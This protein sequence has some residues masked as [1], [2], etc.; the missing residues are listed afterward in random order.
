MIEGPSDCYVL[1][2]W[3]GRKNIYQQIG[4]TR[5]NV[6]NL[7]TFLHASVSKKADRAAIGSPLA[8]SSY[9][10]RMQGGMGDLL[11]F[12]KKGDENSVLGRLKTL[13][14][15]F[16]NTKNGSPQILAEY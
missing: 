10:S 2:D 3:K 8:A 1:I 4:R 12:L 15:H 6:L 14:K 5:S 11:K 13:Q 7:A 9:V 16:T